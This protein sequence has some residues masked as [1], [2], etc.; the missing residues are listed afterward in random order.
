MVTVVPGRG[1]HKACLTDFCE[2]IPTFTD[3]WGLSCPLLLSLHTVTQLFLQ[4]L[5]WWPNHY[6]HCRCL[7]Q[8]PLSLP[9]STLSLS[10]DNS[11]CSYTQSTAFNRISCHCIFLGQGMPLHHSDQIKGLQSLFG[12]KQLTLCEWVRWI[13]DNYRDRSRAVSDSHLAT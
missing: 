1:W 3:N 13:L 11:F 2:N 8:M 12:V 7:C 5:F 6:L 10:F 4:V 9:L